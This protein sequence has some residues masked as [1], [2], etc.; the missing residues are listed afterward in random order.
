MVSLFLCHLFQELNREEPG[1][2]GGPSSER[3][4]LDARGALVE[5]RAVVSRERLTLGHCLV[6]SVLI[7][8]ISKLVSKSSI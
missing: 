5:R 6:L 3:Y 7:V 2:I 1:G 4:V 8:R